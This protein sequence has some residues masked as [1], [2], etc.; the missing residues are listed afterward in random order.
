V[1]TVSAGASYSLGIRRRSGVRQGGA[2]VS[3]SSYESRARVARPFLAIAFAAALASCGGDSSLQIPNS[4][5]L[6][7]ADGAALPDTVPN[8]EHDIVITS[9]TANVADNNTY[10]M[11]YTGTTDGTPGVVA[12]DHGS[13]TIGSSTFVFRSSVLNGQTYIAALVGS[14]FRAAVPGALFGSST[15]TFQMLFSSAQ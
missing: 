12:T 5:T 13:W 15:Q 7:T 6:Q 8:A 11:T 3:L 14:T 4:W 1:K 10:T 9:A 2:I